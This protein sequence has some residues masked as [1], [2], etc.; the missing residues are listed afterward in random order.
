MSPSSCR[1]ILSNMVYNIYI[2]VN[3]SA[4]YLNGLFW[5]INWYR[6]LNIKY[7]LTRTGGAETRFSIK[8]FYLQPF[9][10]FRGQT[11]PGVALVQ[12]NRCILQVIMHNWITWFT[13]SILHSSARASGASRRSSVWLREALSIIVCAAR[14]SSAS[15]YNWIT[16][17][18]M[19]T[20]AH[21]MQQFHLVY[22]ISAMSWQRI[23]CLWFW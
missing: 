5:I 11:S 16:Y 6:L 1:C 18:R 14:P 4:R 19:A 10:I 7:F 23:F 9:L 17:I 8:R 20:L 2:I 13:M 21:I 22:V 3:S 15:R 12:W